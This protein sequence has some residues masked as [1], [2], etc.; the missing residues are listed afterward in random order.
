MLDH[1]CSFA[2][3]IGVGEGPSMVIAMA[4]DI[5][6]IE[7]TIAGMATEVTGGTET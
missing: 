1:P 7:A 2:L 5:T 6:A 3:S 4:L